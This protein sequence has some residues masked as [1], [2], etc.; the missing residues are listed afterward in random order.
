[1]NMA[2]PMETTTS[3]H[4]LMPCIL[5]LVLFSC[6]NFMVS[7]GVAYPFDV[8]LLQSL[9]NIVF[10]VAALIFHIIDLWIKKGQLPT[11]YPESIY[12]KDKGLIPGF[13]YG[14][15]G[16]G[17]LFMAQFALIWGWNVD[18][19]SRGV[20][21]LILGGIPPC[22]SLFSFLI[23]GERLTLVRIIGM[24]VSI[25]G[26]VLLGIQK[27]MG[28]SIWLSFAF[29]IFCLI[30]LGTRDL[31]SRLVQVKGMSVYAAGMLNAVGEGLCG[32]V[33]LLW[34]LIFEGFSEL[35]SLNWLFLKCFIGAIFI[36]FGNFFI[37]YSIMTGN[38]GV[39]LTIVNTNVIIFLLLDLI[40]Y[41]KVPGV[42]SLIACVIIMLGVMILIC[43]DSI[44]GV[45]LK[46]KV[47]LIS[48]KL[49]L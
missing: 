44:K 45:I 41:D 38:I 42:L 37:I 33:L 14:V 15:I 36:G 25:G 19:S 49:E 6:G 43:G 40:F 21:F 17:L 3:L 31:F 30:I 10:F 1:M 18:P 23:F 32:L 13:T 48:H 28:D 2:R 34:I 39:V 11:A 9:G 22:V 16:G 12:L 4:W 47:T 20:T 46:K 35:F 27:A 7:E 8:K 29:G 24:V 26:I 5:G